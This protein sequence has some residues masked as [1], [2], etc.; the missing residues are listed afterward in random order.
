MNDLKLQPWKLTARELAPGVLWTNENRVLL[1]TREGRLLEVDSVGGLVLRELELGGPCVGFCRSKSELIVARTTPGALL[2]VDPATL[3]VTMEIPVATPLEVAAHP[4]H[5][6]LFVRS[7][8]RYGL[9]VINARTRVLQHLL[10]PP[11]SQLL[12]HENEPQWHPLNQPDSIDQIAAPLANQFLARDGGVLHRWTIFSGQ[13]SYQQSTS[14]SNH[15]GFVT[16]GDGSL[17]VTSSTLFGTDDLQRAQGMMQGRYFPHTAGIAGKR[18]HVFAADGSTNLR[19]FSRRGEVLAEYRWGE[20][21]ET[22]R[23]DRIYVTPAEDRLLVFHEQRLYSVEMPAAF[24]GS[25]NPDGGTEKPQQKLQVAGWTWPECARP[26]LK[27]VEV[28][29]IAHQR[30]PGIPSRQL[31]G[32]AGLW[33]WSP[34]GGTLYWLG[35][36]ALCRVNCSKFKV[37]QAVAVP[38][39]RS[40]THLLLSQAGLVAISKQPTRLWI[41]D[42]QSLAGVRV[43]DAPDLLANLRQP[44][45][46]AATSPASPLLVGLAASGGLQV[47]DLRTGEL[48]AQAP[49]ASVTGQPEGTS[50]G[51]WPPIASL[52]MSADGGSLF[53]VKDGVHRSAIG[54][55][56]L[57]YEQSSLPLKMRR[58]GL[59]SGD[60]R[61]IAVQTDAEGTLIFEAANLKSVRSEQVRAAIDERSVL[62]QMGERIWQSG[63]SVC[64]GRL[65]QPVY[66]TLPETTHSE[67]RLS[68]DGR[69]LL[70]VGSQHAYVVDTSLAAPAPSNSAPSRT[71]VE[72]AQLVELSGASAFEIRQVDEEAALEMS[73][74]GASRVAKI[75]AQEIRDLRRW[76][77]FFGGWA[78]ALSPGQRQVRQTDLAS[79]SA[80]QARDNLAKPVFQHRPPDLGGR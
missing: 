12:G 24:G 6:L 32:G 3:A 64:D 36:E 69:L 38:R 62:D 74:A 44:Q 27:L 5:D 70:A 65:S 2:C 49:L 67:L 68:P 11:D 50:A 59:L 26:E 61:L 41:L 15:E 13:L 14:S 47:I 77:L 35:K 23:T 57:V 19:V 29:P 66:C 40:F 16:S 21:R 28:A 73:A 43:I 10:T 37:E 76:F 42:P 30:S 55:L 25:S 80:L 52:A 1:L 20:G 7:A 48:T 34:D 63:L 4:E 17:L 72:A 60:G 46:M 22:G 71:V 54:I 51:D 56:G 75:E 8:G 45:L 79:G 78:L 31:T 9:A 18:G 39:E 58:P 33:R 53:V